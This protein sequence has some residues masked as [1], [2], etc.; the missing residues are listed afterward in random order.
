MVEASRTI[1]GA[2]ERVLRATGCGFERIAD[3]PAYKMSYASAE[4]S[5]DIIIFADEEKGVVSFICPE[6]FKSEKESPGMLKILN[7]VNSNILLGKLIYL[8]D[9]KTVSAVLTVPFSSGM[10]GTDSLRKALH[11]LLA[12]VEHAAPYIRSSH[13]APEGTRPEKPFLPGPGPAEIN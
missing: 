9:Q 1:I 7:H 4:G 13:A 8:E 11:S 12:V 10:A 5:W 3:E 6:I 2:V